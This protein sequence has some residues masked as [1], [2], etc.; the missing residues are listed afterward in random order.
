MGHFVILVKASSC[1]SPEKNILQTFGYKKAIMHTVR[2]GQQS[3]YWARNNS[4]PSQKL[5][6]T[7]PM[8]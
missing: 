7:V 5:L 4:G 6:Q 8:K 3:S 2:Q 1:T